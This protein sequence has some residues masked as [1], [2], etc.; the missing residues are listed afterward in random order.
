MEMVTCGAVVGSRDGETMPMDA[1]DALLGAAD[2]APL[3]LLPAD[4]T[5]DM[6]PKLL[7]RRAG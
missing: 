7:G 3:T 6:E 1:S 5:M 4:D 2:G